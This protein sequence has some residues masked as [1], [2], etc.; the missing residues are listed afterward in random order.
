MAM[1]PPHYPAFYLFSGAGAVYVWRCWYW[2]D[3]AYG[4]VL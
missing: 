2:E 4:L 3:N 1:V